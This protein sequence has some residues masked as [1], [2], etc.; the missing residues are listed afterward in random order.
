MLLSALLWDPVLQLQL[1]PNRQVRI[2]PPCRAVHRFRKPGDGLRLPTQRVWQGMVWLLDPCR[3]S[4]EFLS[5]VLMGLQTSC[6][7][8]RRASPLKLRSICLN[9]AKAAPARIER[10]YACFL[11]INSAMYL[12]LQASEQKWTAS[13]CTASASFQADKMS[14]LRRTTVKPTASAARP[15][16]HM[17]I[18]FFTLPHE[19]HAN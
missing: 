17:P 11:P 2:H 19:S 6:F 1:G 3:V 9:P 12:S 5:S 7:R 10:P 18:G 15:R 8:G 14:T 4:L 16:I 13:G